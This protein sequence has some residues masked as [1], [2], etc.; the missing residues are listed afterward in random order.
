MQ[1]PPNRSFDPSLLRDA[2]IRRI[3][4]RTSAEG[5]IRVPAVPAMIDEYLQLCGNVCATLGVWY[6]P[7]QFAQLRSALEVELAKAFKAFP[8][9][10]VLISYHAPFGTGVNFHV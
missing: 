8:R 2:V 10:D 1:D 9:S 7:E 4:R 6:A 3:Y 5:T